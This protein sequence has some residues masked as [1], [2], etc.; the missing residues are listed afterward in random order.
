MALVVSRALPTARSDRRERHVLIVEDESTIRGMLADVL[1]DAGYA[2]LEAADGL[3]ALRQLRASRPDL[4]VLDLM[5]PGMSGW[6]FLERSRKRLERLNIPVVILSAI[7]GKGDYPTT[8]GVAAWLTKPIDVDKLVAAVE[9]MVGPARPVGRPPTP[10]PPQILIV[11]DESTIREVIAE[12]LADEGFQPSVAETIAEVEQIVAREPPALILLDLM[13]PGTSGFTFLR[14]RLESP[15]LAAIP[16]V[17]LSAAPSD[18]LV[19]AKELGADAFLSKPFDI[20]ALTA[21]VR[22]FVR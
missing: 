19:E 22:S 3:E 7:A 14:H 11:E 20:D 2:V 15:A 13:L 8:L 18:R 16:V 17:V 1:G 12:H 10:L 21:L 9:S 6:Q 5:M 4:I